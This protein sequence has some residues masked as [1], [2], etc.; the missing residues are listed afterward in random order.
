MGYPMYMDSENMSQWEY[1]EG[2]KICG[3]L[4][5]YVLVVEDEL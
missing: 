1:Q 2:F 3:I 4:I 5:K